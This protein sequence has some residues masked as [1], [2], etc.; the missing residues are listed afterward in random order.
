M[1]HRYF[2]QWVTCDACKKSLRDAWLTVDGVVSVQFL[3]DKQVVMRMDHHVDLS[4]LQDAIIDLKKYRI[5]DVPFSLVP[6]WMTWLLIYKWLVLIISLIIVVTVLDVLWFRGL[7]WWQ[8]VML[9]FMGRWFI[10]FSALKLYNLKGFVDGFVSY[11]VV[12][13]RWQWYA[14]VYP[15]IELALWLA[16]LFWRGVWVASMV[17][18]I[19]MVVGT[20]GV[21]K[22]L[23]KKIQCV[24]IG[25]FFSLPLTKVTVV[26][27]LFMAAMA[28]VMI[29]FW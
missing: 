22:A 15:F 1:E 14:W 13:M 10:F 9:S 20:I 11:D 12:A 29:V 26:E 4:L 21:W 16:F 23:G 8:S 2:V 3:G 5:S 24:C 27:N 18:V 28:F 6:S 19:V 25:T 7:V 17:T